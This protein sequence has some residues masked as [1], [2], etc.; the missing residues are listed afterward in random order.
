MATKSQLKRFRAI[1]HKLK[2][3]VTLAGNGVSDAV[4]K[5]INRAIDDHE[6]IKI[7]VNAENRQDRSNLIA[8]VSQLSATEIVQTIGNIALLYKPAVQP[9]PKLSNILR[10]DVL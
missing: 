2:P 8:K 4:M 1:G 7:R 5:E 6:L 10:A 9:N 3:I